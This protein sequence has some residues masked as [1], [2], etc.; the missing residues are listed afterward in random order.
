M[1]A[2]ADA[3]ILRARQRLQAQ[4][5]QACQLRFDAAGRVEGHTPRLAAAPGEA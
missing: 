4:M 5:T 2:P 1:R 3:Q